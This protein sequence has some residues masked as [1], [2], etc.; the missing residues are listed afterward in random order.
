VVPD[1]FCIFVT[2]HVGQL[3]FPHPLDKLLTGEGV[4]KFLDVGPVGV[5]V[6][7]FV[8]SRQLD[9]FD[10]GMLKDTFNPSAPASHIIAECHPPGAERHPRWV[11]GGYR[12]V[13]EYLNYL[14][15]KRDHARLRSASPGFPPLERVIAA[16][17]AFWGKVLDHPA[18]LE[19]HDCQ[20]HPRRGSRAR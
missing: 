8:K 10:P 16:R 12:D 19:E 9:F 7:I 20:P 13:A 5:L 1:H 17:R 4:T 2:Q 3:I 18:R 14:R 11:V 15:L 6:A